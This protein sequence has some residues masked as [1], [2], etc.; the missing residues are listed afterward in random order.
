[1][2]R[3]DEQVHEARLD[4]RPQGAVVGAQTADEELAGDDVTALGGPAGAHR[5]LAAGVHEERV[6]VELLQGRQ[7]RDGRD[8]DQGRHCGGAARV[9][10]G[11]PPHLRVS[12]PTLL[13]HVGSGGVA[14]R[15]QRSAGGDHLVGAR[16][17]HA[18]GLRHT[19]PHRSAL[20]APAR[21]PA[22]QARGAAPSR[23]GGRGRGSGLASA[24]RP[25]P[26]ALVAA[27][28]AGHAGT[29]AEG[30][31]ARGARAAQAGPSAVRRGGARGPDR[32]R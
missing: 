29:G 15:R 8:A 3:C 12:P 18:G 24:R 14:R 11:V 7:A 31:A 4:V 6:R 2:A 21:A 17:L 5:V 1:M 32:G 30:R 10:H 20:R 19:R 28:R 27:A 23:G 22:A 9:S 26:S 13:L 16:H 25:S